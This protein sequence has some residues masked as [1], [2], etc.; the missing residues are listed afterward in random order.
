MALLCPS[1]TVVALDTSDLQLGLDQGEQFG[2][3]AIPIESTSVMVG[4]AYPMRGV[5]HPH[6]VAWGKTI[7]S[8]MN[9]AIENKITGLSCGRRPKVISHTLRQ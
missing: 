1:C 2:K 6:D 3:W 9:N 7:V 8:N 4:L 5:C